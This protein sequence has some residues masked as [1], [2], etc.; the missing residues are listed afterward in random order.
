MTTTAPMPASHVRGRNELTMDGQAWMLIE[1]Y[2]MVA[3]PA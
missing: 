1:E 2:A 3:D